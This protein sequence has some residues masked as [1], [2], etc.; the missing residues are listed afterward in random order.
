MNSWEEQNADGEVV[1][2]LWGCSL[3]GVSLDFNEEHPF[4]GQKNRN[5]ITKMTFNLSSGKSTF[6]KLHDDFC[7]EFPVI[8]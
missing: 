4:Y 8:P 7:G 2:T 1:I 5:T 3:D 6:E